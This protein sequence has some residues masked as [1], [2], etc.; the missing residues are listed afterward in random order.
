MFYYAQKDSEGRPTVTGTID[1]IERIP[2]GYEQ[3]TEEEFNKYKEWGPYLRKSDG[4]I[5]FV[6]ANQKINELSSACSNEIKNGFDFNGEHYSLDLVDQININSM[7]QTVLEKTIPVAQNISL[8]SA[9][10]EIVSRQNIT[11]H[12]DN[13]IEQEYSDAEI[14]SLKNA[15]DNHIQS[16]RQKFNEMKQTLLSLGATE[17][18]AKII[19][20]MN[21]TN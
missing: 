16:C 5:G 21:W 17:E 13:G 3:I 18:D 19:K 15:M 4:S 14:I 11:Y 7:Y 8:L 2:E 20:N 9:N 6:K 10:S 12:A 1:S